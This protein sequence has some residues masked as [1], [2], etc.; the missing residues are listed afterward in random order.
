MHIFAPMKAVWEQEI[1]ECL[2]CLRR[3]GVLLYPTDT[4]W[5]LGC[6]PRNAE[7]VTNLFELKGRPADKSLIL[8][9]GNVDQVKAIVGDI[10]NAILPELATDRPTTIVYPSCITLAPGV[11]GADGSVAIRIAKDPF[12]QALAAAYGF[13]IVSTS[14]NISGQ[15]FAGSFADIDRSII[16][17]ADKVVSWRQTEK[18]VAQPSRILKVLD[19][20]KVQLIRP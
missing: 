11:A 6:D 12:C 2:D 7:A 19:D 9:A 1:E 13:P 10:P 18:I 16:A 15:A 20:G 3:G 14:A 8:L 5:G 17:G 4:I